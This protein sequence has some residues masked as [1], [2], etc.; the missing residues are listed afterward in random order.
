MEKDCPEI[1]DGYTLEDITAPR[2]KVGD[3]ANIL[4]VTTETI[5]YYEKMGIIEAFRNES[6]TRYFGSDALFSLCMM[7]YKQ[8][9]GFSNQEI[10]L[11]QENAPLTSVRQEMD[12]KRKALRH[13]LML[14]QLK[15]EK[16]EIACSRMDQL[17]HHLNEPIL[18]TSPEVTLWEFIDEY[19]ITEL[20][21]IEKGLLNDYLAITNM[22]FV[23]T[24]YRPYEKRIT[25]A[26]RSYGLLVES[27]YLERLN[28]DKDKASFVIPSTTC[29][30]V[31]LSDQGGYMVDQL[32]NLIENLKGEVEFTG[33]PF[34]S[35][36]F[37][38]YL[39]GKRT[40]YFRVFIPVKVKDKA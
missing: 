1:R 35:V 38:E 11:H 40:Y 25:P 3:L 26:D 4:N 6:G 24:N 34:G 36:E 19:Q 32:S 28:I 27:S 7:K 10:A 12:E 22:G 8:L 14:L 9:Y 30:E 39:N 21:Y 33:P 17:I 15:I 20:N 31:Y 29:L 18:T 5:R 37:V 16:M 13:E 23:V 2:Y